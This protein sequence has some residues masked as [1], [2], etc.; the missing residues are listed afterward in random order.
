MRIALALAAMLICACSPSMQ[1]GESSGVTLSVEPSTVSAGETVTLVLRNGSASAV[2]YNLCTSGLERNENGAWRT[3][4]S[5]RVCTMELRTLAAGEDA[6]YPLEMPGGLEA[7]EY[8]FLTNLDMMGAA[9]GGSVR[10]GA[11]RVE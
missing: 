6:R 5:D 4:P 9:E 10:S 8:R 11:F 1:S 7:G 3:V 2:G